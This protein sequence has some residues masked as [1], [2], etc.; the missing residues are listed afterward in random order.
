MG[1][2]ACTLLLLIVTTCNVDKLTNSQPPVATLAVAPGKLNKT[3]AVGSTALRLDSV[4]LANV[5]EGAL[6]WSAGSMLGSGWL[7]I[8]PRNGATPAWLRV[9]LDPAG[10]TPG[11]YHDTVVV[12][13]GNAAHS[14]AAVPVDF[15]V[16]PCVAAAIAPDALLT[17]SLTRQSCGAPHRAGSFAQ[18]YSFAGRAGDSISVLMA[19]PALDG[20]V[21]LDSS[22]AGT[23]PPLAQN[24]RCGTSG[25]ACLRYQL[26]RVGGTYTIEA[27]SAAASTTGAY[28]LSVTRPRAPAAPASVAQL[29]SDSATGLPVG[30]V[31]DEPTVVVRGVVTDPDI[32]DTLRLQ[33]EVQPV[34]TAFTDLPTA[35]SD[36]VADPN[37]GDQLRLDVEV[38]PLGTAFSGVPS[39]S[40]ASVA[41]GAT[42]TATV[43]GL[44][45][46]VA[47]HWQ[48]RAVDQ[49]GRAGP[50][51]AFG[52][53][54]ET[55][56][57]F[58]V[59]VT[60]T[61][62]SF[63]VP[64]STTAAG[65]AITPAV[66]VT[67]QDALG[68]RV[69]S[70]TGDVTVVIATNPA[71]G[72][73]GGT[74]TVAA[75]NGV[76]TFANLTINRVGQGYTLQASAG[77]L[78]QP[79]PPFDITAAAAGKLAMVTQP[80]A[81]AQSG[82]AFAT[83]PAVQVQDPSGN[84]VADPNVVVTAVIAS[85]PSGATVA[86]ASATTSA[87]GRATFGEIGRAHV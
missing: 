64:P 51:V 23:A 12:S 62:L 44:N 58:R 56:A 86:S 34:G 74:A 42:A 16:H 14:P 22:T 85:G 67:A 38:E 43:A 8:T 75:V 65:A 4:A 28:T 52:D 27:T 26:L 53:N 35:A 68:T 47:Y 84:P 87:S 45:D 39:G 5:G 25:D 40:G 3:A 57:D 21:V 1:V 73:L 59:A 37:A 66:Q 19:A 24:D 31:T 81:A 33:V 30:T 2:A 20:Y 77:A 80:S 7:S 60:V 63:T 69:V 55:G 79:S 6:S 13:A 29:R 10:L 18:L 82:V 11:A 49:T 15:V 32:A 76:A 72:T 50:W 46:N 61:Q 71:G 83:Q 41:N 36:P 70:F 78:S 17:D 54:A 9:Q 48:A